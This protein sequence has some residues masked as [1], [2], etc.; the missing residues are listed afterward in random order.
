MSNEKR[1]NVSHY[2][3]PEPDRAKPAERAGRR[4]PYAASGASDM[5]EPDRASDFA[6]E[7][8]KCAKMH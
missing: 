2:D 1:I 7:M 4:A 6:G 3:M 5:P 8:I